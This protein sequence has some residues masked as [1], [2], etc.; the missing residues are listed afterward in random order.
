MADEP[1]AGG[2]GAVLALQ[3]RGNT[4]IKPAFLQCRKNFPEI[5]GEG[6]T[7]FFLSL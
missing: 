2:E 4:T 7:A 5:S 3:S 6:L 1:V